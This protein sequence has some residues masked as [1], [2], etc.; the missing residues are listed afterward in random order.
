MPHIPLLV[1]PEYIES[2]LAP[3]TPLT[4]YLPD[5]PLTPQTDSLHPYT[6]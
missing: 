3:N 5:A 1:I 4:P 2:L 6:S